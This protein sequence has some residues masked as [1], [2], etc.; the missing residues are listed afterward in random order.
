MAKSANGVQ[1]GGFPAILP[2][3]NVSKAEQMLLQGADPS[4]ASYTCCFIFG[5]QSSIDEANTREDLQALLHKYGC[6]DKNTVG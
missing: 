6:E 4:Y 3:G 2:E 5:H 1:L